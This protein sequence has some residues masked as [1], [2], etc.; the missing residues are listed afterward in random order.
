MNHNLAYRQR[1]FQDIILE[2]MRMYSNHRAAL[3]ALVQSPIFKYVALS[4]DAFG[5]VSYPAFYVSEDDGQLV[6][7]GDVSDDETRKAA[8]LGFLINKLGVDV[9]KDEINRAF[10]GT[11]EDFIATTGEVAR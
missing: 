5:K 11:L 3:S 8:T 1:L 10:Q 7:A 9:D 4:R 6:I 2:M